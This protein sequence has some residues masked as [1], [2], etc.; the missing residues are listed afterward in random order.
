MKISRPN[1]LRRITAVL[2][3]AM[4]LVAAAGCT[5][6]RHADNPVPDGDTVEVVIRD[7]SRPDA[8]RP[9]KIIEINDTV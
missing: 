7:A 3:A 2:P 5:G 9:V 6:H 1:L 8:P 4:L